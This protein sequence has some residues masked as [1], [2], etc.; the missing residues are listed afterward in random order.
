VNE[1]VGDIGASGA[2]DESEREMVAER[3]LR[4]ESERNE[5]GATG[6]A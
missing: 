4:A 3:E 1:S 6:E 2:R 5:S